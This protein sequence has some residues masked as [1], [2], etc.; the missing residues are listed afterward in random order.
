MA[1]TAAPLALSLPAMGQT[2][3]GKP[4]SSLVQAAK[5]ALARHSSVI[6]HQDII[7][8]AD[9]S[10]PSRLPR[11]HLLNVADGTMRSFLVAHGRGSDP[12]HTGWLQQ[13]SNAPGSAATSAGSYVTG[14]TYTGQH[15]L[16]QRLSGLDD[17][18][19][20]AES[21][22]IVIHGAWYVSQTLASEHGLL[23]RSE[24]CFAFSESDY[25]D[26]ILALGEGR[27]IYSGKA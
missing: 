27:L 22:G 4:E 5:A 7:G 23:G 16:S 11:F 17:Q 25:R 8:I 9:F 20:N 2:L 19:S 15:G 13:F 18:N 3:V 12:A 14:S 10:A 21:R 1:L 24:G 26:I 6:R